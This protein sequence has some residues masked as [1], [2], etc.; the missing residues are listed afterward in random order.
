[1]TCEVGRV[2]ALVV[3][4]VLVTASLGANE[5]RAQS[6]GALQSGAHQFAPQNPPLSRSDPR[7]VPLQCRT[8]V[9]PV[10]EARLIAPLR[11][12]LQRGVLRILAIGSSSTAGTGSSSPASTY[13]ALLEA[14]LRRIYPDA[15]IT[16]IN[17]GIGGETAIGAA[18]RLQA[19]VGKAR[20]HVVLWQL[21]TNSALAGVKMVRLHKLVTKSLT[22]LRSQRIGVILVDPQYVNK[23]RK[24]IYYARVVEMIGRMAAQEHVPLVRRYASMVA[25]SRRQNLADYLAADRFHLNDLGYRCLAA[26]AAQA[27]MRANQTT[28]QHL[29]CPSGDASCASLVEVARPA[30]TKASDR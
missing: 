16:V 10:A 20:P 21:G 5:T 15:Q 7:S 4:A 8:D 24:N 13:P 23:F 17:R 18:A 27:L 12:A 6:P 28:P 25:I 11:D 22:W 3:A 29:A 30:T 19:E 2:A 9:D 26:Y 14:R 1:M